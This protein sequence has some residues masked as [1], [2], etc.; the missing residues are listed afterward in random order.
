M[1]QGVRKRPL[2]GKNPQ[3]QRNGRGGTKSRQ[4]RAGEGRTSRRCF[5]EHI[6]ARGPALPSK[7]GREEQ[8]PRLGDSESEKKRGQ[9]RNREI[10]HTNSNG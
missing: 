10:G 5:E 3:T 8:S 6:G 9:R 7:T 2:S 1:D 4:K